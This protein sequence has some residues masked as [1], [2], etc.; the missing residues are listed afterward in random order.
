MA[1]TSS[2]PQQRQAVVEAADILV[3]SAV[4]SHT[5]HV[6]LSARIDGGR[7]LLTSHGTVHAVHEEAMA[8]VASDGRVDEGRLAPST[9]EIVPMHAAVYRAWAEVGAVVHTHSPHLTAFALAGRSL[10]CRY[11]VLLRHGQGQAVPVVAWAPR[12]SDASVMGIADALDGHAAT[13]AVLLA[14]HGVLAFSSSP[15]AAAK[16]VVALEEA[17]EGEIRSAAIGGA[18]DLPEGA[19][20]AVRQGM[21]RAR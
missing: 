10:P 21:A 7:M 18:Q 20:E 12:G 4:L 15:T 17:A 19:L 16:L 8:V 9:E 14:N 2:F 3:R 11:E 13:L 6:N 1:A 5:G